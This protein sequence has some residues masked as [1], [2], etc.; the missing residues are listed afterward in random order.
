MCY[1]IKVDGFIDY[2]NIIFG[3]GNGGMICISNV[4]VGV[5]NNDVVN[6]V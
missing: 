5:N 6:Y 1:D 4:F 2:S 3:G